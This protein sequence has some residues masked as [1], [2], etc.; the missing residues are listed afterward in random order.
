MNRAPPPRAS[1]GPPYGK[2]DAALF[3]DLGS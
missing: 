1:N 2:S 3:T